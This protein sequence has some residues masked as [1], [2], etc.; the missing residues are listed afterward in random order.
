MQP[1][2]DEGKA[3]VTP[4]N[5]PVVLYI[6][7]DPCAL[8]ALRRLFGS[9]PYAVVTVA[10]AG[11]ALS[12]LRHQPV[13]VVISALWLPEMSG[14]EFLWEIE[15]RWPWIGRALLTAHPERRAET[16]GL[17]KRIDLLLPSSW[18]GETVRQQV[19]QLLREAER[20]RSQDMKVR[21]SGSGAVRDGE[22]DRLVERIVKRHLVVCVDDDPEVL[23]A[24]RRSLRREPYAVLTTS[25]PEQALEWVR[26]RDVS[27]LVTD[28]RMPGMTGTD[29]AKRVFAHSPATACIVLTAYAAWTAR[30]HRFRQSVQCLVSKPWDDAMLRKALLG[31]LEGRPT[32]EPG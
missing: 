30:V 12:V 7:D 25:L 22:G 10:S 6:D 1:M 3:L 18:D 19:R 23:S 9:E 31:F 32:V 27:A 21:D 26:S 5:E 11:Q 24:L 28:E 29:L 8:E 14:P 17:E 2:R 4:M 16:R 20:R 13:R 15:Q